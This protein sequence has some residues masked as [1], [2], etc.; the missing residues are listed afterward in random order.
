M[1][2]SLS[3]PLRTSKTL[4]A[5]LEQR[6]AVR[7]QIAV[8]DPDGSVARLFAPRKNLIMDGGLDHYASLDFVDLFSYACVG[9]GTNPVMRYSAPVTF[10]QTG[11][12]VTASAAFFAPS[13]VGYI[14]KYGASGSGSGGAEQYITGYT[15]A[16][17]VTVSSNAVVGT[18]YGALWYVNQT[19]L[20]TQVKATNTYQPT[21]GG[22]VF[23]LGSGTSTFTHTRVFL[24]SAE[25]STIT[26]Q[27]IGWSWNG[28]NIFG[29]DLITPSGVTLVSGQQL[30]VTINVALQFGPTAIT[31]V[32]DVSGGA[33]NTAGNA[34]LE[35]MRTQSSGT[36]GANA[37]STV[38]ADNT[39]NNSNACEPS[40]L[41]A[42]AL[43]VGT[44]T[45]QTAFQNTYCAVSGVTVNVVGL[46][47]GSYSPGQFSRTFTATMSS[48]QNVG[49]PYTGIAITNGNGGGWCF[50]LKLTTPI[51]KDASH[52]L[53]LTFTI[54]WGRI[55]VN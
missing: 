13:D 34:I 7:Y 10:T 40:G 2:A 45:Q 3:P 21:G 41:S 52:S 18:S 12:V 36:Y 28:T 26:Y 29:R 22:S 20:Q 33:W 39:T 8:L 24:F 23:A 14:L 19:T 35:Y 43:L 16:V 42:M 50:S 1:K 38:N 48:S 31:A 25:S 5:T 17:S 27:E 30:Q 11:N 9:T 4:R 32:G 15:S 54:G 51:S 46:T 37:F 55:L 53:V 44:W 49:G 47:A 6:A